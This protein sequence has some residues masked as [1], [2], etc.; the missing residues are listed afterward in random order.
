LEATKELAIIS[1]YGFQRK[2]EKK[3]KERE[4]KKMEGKFNGGAPDCT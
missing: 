2:E 3:R 1:S 4:K